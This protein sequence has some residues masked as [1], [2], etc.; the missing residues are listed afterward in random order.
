MCLN[1]PLSS[2]ETYVYRHLYCLYWCE[3]NDRIRNRKPKHHAPAFDSYSVSPGHRCSTS[4]GSIS[5]KYCLKAT[6]P[7]CPDPLGWET[8][9]HKR[10]CLQTLKAE[11]KLRTHYSRPCMDTAPHPMRAMPVLCIP[12]LRQKRKQLPLGD[13]KLGIGCCPPFFKTCRFVWGY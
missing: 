12:E 7:L 5:G 3:K 13:E 11:E 4:S 8:I 1:K 6:A 10:W 9:V 2:A